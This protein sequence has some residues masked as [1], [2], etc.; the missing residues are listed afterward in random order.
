MQKKTGNNG[1][2]AP[3]DDESV[4]EKEKFLTTLHKV[5][6]EIGNILGVGNR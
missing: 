1:S 2:L 3:S 6:G 5:I 4:N